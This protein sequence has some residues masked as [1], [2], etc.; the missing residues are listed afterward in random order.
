MFQQNVSVLGA[1]G[2]KAHLLIIAAIEARNG[3]LAKKYMQD[4][5]NYTME[6]TSMLDTK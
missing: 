6:Q 1:A 5:L 4:H 2:A 3:D